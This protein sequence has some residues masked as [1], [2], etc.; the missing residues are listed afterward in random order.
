MAEKYI[1]LENDLWQLGDGSFFEGAKADLPKSN[2]SK[3]GGAG[4]TYPE[5]YLKE[6]GFIKPEKKSEKKKVETKAVKPSENK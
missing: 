2:A 1:K 6:I 3:L 5:S 4:K